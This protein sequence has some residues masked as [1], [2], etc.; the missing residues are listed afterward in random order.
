MMDTTKK[1][2]LDYLL[3]ASRVFLIL[4]LLVNLTV[5]AIGY[6]ILPEQIVSR[7]NPDFEIGLRNPFSKEYFLATLVGFSTFIF[8]LGFVLPLLPRKK[9][10]TT[11]TTGYWD[12]EENIVLKEK[13]TNFWAM[14]IFGSLILYATLV[15]IWHV[16]VN[17]STPPRGNAYPLYSFVILFS[18]GILL[19]LLPY[20]TLAFV[21]PFR[22]RKAGGQNQEPQV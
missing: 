19:P 4:A 7:A 13:I 14:M 2:P 5:A 11:E 8:L 1:T 12:R 6:C 21:K 9:L 16:Q 20:S 22:E 15:L 3:F 18:P 10:E 17:L